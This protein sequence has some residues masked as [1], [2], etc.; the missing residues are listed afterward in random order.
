MKFLMVTAEDLPSHL[1]RKY[2]SLR[3]ALARQG[4]SLGQYSVGLSL[5]VM[6]R[7]TGSRIAKMIVGLQYDLD[8]YVRSGAYRRARQARERKLGVIRVSTASRR[9]AV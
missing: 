5:G 6:H 2:R 4:A 7:S 1:R 9:R 3:R 8:D